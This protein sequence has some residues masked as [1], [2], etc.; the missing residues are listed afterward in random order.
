MGLGVQQDEDWAEAGYYYDDIFADPPVWG[1][2][3]GSCWS[4]MSVDNRILLIGT[5]AFFLVM[6][7]LTM[8]TTTRP[9]PSAS[10]ATMASTRA[11][12][13]AWS[14]RRSASVSG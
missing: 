14:R 4:R 2:S 3:R 8:S 5:T 12:P 13:A 6:A 7:L 9:S 10:R 11:A 1:Y